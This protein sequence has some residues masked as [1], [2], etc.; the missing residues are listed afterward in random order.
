VPHR[1]RYNF[2]TPHFA[3]G[4]TNGHYGTHDKLV[5]IELAAGEDL[6]VIF[7]SP[8]INGH[9]Y[10][11]RRLKDRSGHTKPVHMPLNACSVQDRELLMT[12]LDLD[13]SAAEKFEMNVVFPAAASEITLDGKRMS[14]AKPVEI[15]AQL[16]SVVAL[17]AGSGAVAFRLFHADGDPRIVLKADAE[18]LEFGAARLTSFHKSSPHVRI[19]LLFLAGKAA[20][21]Q[22][23]SSALAAATIGDRTEGSTWTAYVKLG[24]KFLEAARDTATRE[25]IF[26]RKNGRDIEP[27]VLTIKGQDRNTL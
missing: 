3:I 27:K 17:K 26:R 13:G 4:S 23:L 2:I 15:D 7:L 19:G 24:G 9:P 6:P 14:V 5:N 8:D 1:D 22:E 18:G 25:I 20:Q 12:T 21:M 16:G 11:Q 10:G